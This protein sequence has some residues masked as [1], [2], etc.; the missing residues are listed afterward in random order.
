MS[1]QADPLMSRI[2]GPVTTPWE[3]ILG[4]GWAAGP[5][6]SGN[7]P[8]PAMFPP[9]AHLPWPP[10]QGAPYWGLMMPAS[11][12]SVQ[13]KT[14]PGHK[15]HPPH[16]RDSASIPSLIGGGH[17]LPPSIRPPT[18]TRCL[19]ICRIC[20]HNFSLVGPSTN[21]IWRPVWA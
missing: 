3:S 14:C 17:P 11:G 16:S 12:G 13:L 4:Q 7:S 10:P 8:C 21:S 19:I 5:E 9:Y 1:I 15:A 20:L 18:N 2:L 6:G